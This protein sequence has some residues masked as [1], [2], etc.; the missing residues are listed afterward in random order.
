MT[1]NGTNNK[2]GFPFGKAII[3]G[4]ILWFVIG[5]LVAKYQAKRQAEINKQ[6][7]EEAG[8]FWGGVIKAV[9]E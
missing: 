7:A 6:N 9:S 8:A 4:L 1:Q 5:S 3:V 2:Q